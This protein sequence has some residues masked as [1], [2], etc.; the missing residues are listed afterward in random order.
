MV[1]END[2]S[3]SLLR[4]SI[5]HSPP[6][7]LVKILDSLSSEMT[8]A[9]I[10][11][12]VAL[13]PGVSAQ[14]LR[15]ANSSFFGLRGKVTTIDRAISVLGTKM[16][17]NLVISAA[18][19]AHTARVTLHH[20]EASVFWQHSFETAEFAR[21][22]AVTAKM[23]GD[24]AWV[25]GILHDLGRIILHAHKKSPPDWLGRRHSQH[26]IAEWEFTQFQVQSPE[27]G[28]K[29]LKMW[30]I[31]PHLI[32][33]IATAHD[34]ARA[35][36]PGKILFLAKEFSALSSLSGRSSR[37]QPQLVA[38][39]LHECGL[40]EGKFLLAASHLPITAR[41]A[42]D[43]ARMICSSSSAAPRPRLPSSLTVVSPLE[44]SLALTLLRLQGADPQLRTPRDLVRA[45]AA[46]EAAERD[47]AEAPPLSKPSSFLDSILI[48]F[49]KAPPPPPEEAPPPFFWPR[50]LILDGASLEEI[51]EPI[52]NT[53]V[54]KVVDSPAVA[55]ELPRY[56][57]IEDFGDDLDSSRL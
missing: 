36:L 45:I 32:D 27:I 10:A 28:L 26:E 34:P 7:L 51:P 13:E 15:L 53:R 54:F 52:P 50:V 18:L 20:L 22:F 35:S 9:Q 38:Q 17:R 48:R 25:A 5:L 41:R 47:D 11:E 1:R 39:L 49:G 56:F 55:G 12:I 46:R 14:I 6:A 2:P 40:N 21:E 44:E 3:D 33:A 23:N 30:N 19:A 31:P 37:L 29:L 8:A 16:V 57:R 43:I 4:S 42:R 24:E